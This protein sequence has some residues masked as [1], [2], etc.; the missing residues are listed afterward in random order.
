MTVSLGSPAWGWA[1]DEAAMR[2]LSEEAVATALA[3]GAE[4]ADARIVEIEEE[5][6]YAIS[7]RELDWRIEHSL[8]I[9]VRVLREGCWGFGS[10]ALEGS[11]A[12][13]AAAHAALRMSG[14]GDRCG[15]AKLVPQP[16][17]LGRYA[18]AVK[19]DP[20]EVSAAKKETL[21]RNMLGAAAREPRV[22]NA[23]AGIN[24]KRQRRYFSSSEGSWQVQHLMECGGVFQ[25]WA[26]ADGEVQRRS[27][28][29]SF[30]GNTAALGWE[31]IDSLR[32]DTEA[33]RVVDEACALLKAPSC[34]GGTADLIIG[35]AMT[36]LQIHE[37][38]SHAL[39]LDRI[40]GDEAGFAGTSFIGADAIGRLRYGSPA[41]SFVADP[42]VPSVRG[43]FG[44]D[45]EGQPAHRSVLVEHGV[46][47]DFLSSR[48]TAARIGRQSTATMRA[49]GW[50]YQPLCF[51]TH[52]SLVPGT[53]D[54]PELLDRL[55][56]GYYLDMDRSWSIDDRRLNFQFGTEVAYEVKGG[57][58]GRLLKNASYGGVTPQFWGSVEHVAGQGEVQVFGLPCG[59]GEPKQWG[60]V[61]H[62]VAPILARN[63]RM[64][65]AG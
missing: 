32:L 4:Y 52:V 26:S 44:F 34:P 21:L 42:T 5:R 62:G 7:G 23:V 54:L 60:F 11:E 29:N 36:A 24:A 17:T 12:S 45:D 27:Y 55:R 35:P 46:V 53:G 43:A 14:T 18:S 22:I 13:L 28:P 57:R 59:K 56:D 48:E 58:K 30:H 19:I 50:G 49:D 37:S 33:D 39:E 20:F 31:Y 15:T 47:A 41:V 51:A 61:S 65:V 8:G 64:G 63:V 6:I 10:R 25:V 40:F 2:T 16:G 9:G 38:C 3:S 1:H